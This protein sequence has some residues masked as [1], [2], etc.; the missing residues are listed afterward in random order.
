MAERFARL[1]LA[2]VDQEYPNKI[3]H[4][5]SGDDGRAAAA[6]ADA[7]LL[8]A[9]TTGTPSVHG[10][11]LLARLARLCPRPR[12]RAEARAALARSLTPA[13]IAGEVRYLEGKG[14]VSL[15]AALRPGVAAPARGRAARVAR[16]PRPAPGRRRSRRSRRAP[17]RGSQTG[18]PSCR[19]PIR[20]GEHSQTAFAFGPGRST[21]RAGRATRASARPGRGA[22]RATTTRRTAT[23]RWRT[24]R[25]AR[26][27][28]RPAWPRP[29]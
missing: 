29:T 4:V 3:A 26:T 23:A 19:C 20:V 1:A 16:S 10:H 13:N 17:R 28:C 9:A 27:S 6:R 25:R 11:W 5:L 18:C 8:S 12:S 2:C 21:G 24:S 15:R 14:R 7:R 22:H